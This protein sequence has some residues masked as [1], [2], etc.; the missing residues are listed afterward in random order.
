MEYTHMVMKKEGTAI[1]LP[2]PMDITTFEM[3]G[4]GA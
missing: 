3:E 2:K 4:A 1:T